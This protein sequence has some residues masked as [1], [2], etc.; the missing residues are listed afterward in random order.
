MSKNS[1]IRGLGMQKEVQSVG[2]GGLVAT[3]HACCTGP[4]APPPMHRDCPDV[5][6][7][8]NAENDEGSSPARAQSAAGASR[9]DSQA[10]PGGQAGFDFE[11]ILEDF[12][13][14]TFL[15]RLRLGGRAPRVAQCL[16]LQGNR[17]RSED[18][19]GPSVWGS[20]MLALLAHV[21]YG[22]PAIRYNVTLAASF[23]DSLCL[24]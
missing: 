5:E 1:G 24:D 2:V 4:D 22:T 19:L 14:L 16:S 10:A 20:Y 23:H 11:R 7:G 6:A 17:C 18:C 13:L 8:S 3:F 15:V 21:S 12:V 9:D